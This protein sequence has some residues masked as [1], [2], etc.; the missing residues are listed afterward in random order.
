M[1]TLAPNYS[2]AVQL[3]P[4]RTRRTVSAW[5]LCSLVLAG[6]AS[7]PLSVGMVSAASPAPSVAAGKDKGSPMLEFAV[8]VRS[9]FDDDEAW[10]DLVERIETPNDDD[11]SAD[12]RFVDDQDYNGLTADG[13]RARHARNAFVSFIADERTL[14]NDDAPLLAVWVGTG[15]DDKPA[16]RVAADWLWS[17]ENNINLGNMDWE[18]F[19]RALDPDGVFRGF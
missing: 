15:G 1:R 4:S 19:T 10:S 14:A 16:F 5:A 7:D 8:L 11:F 9:W 3:I 17:V 18:E 2:W 12:V 13:L 6:C